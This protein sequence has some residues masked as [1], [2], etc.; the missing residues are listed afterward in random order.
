MKKVVKKV[1]TDQ[2]SKFCENN[3]NFHKR[4]MEA[5]KNLSAID[6][7]AV[8]IDKVSKNLVPKEA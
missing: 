7:V 3:S 2:L 8:I 5:I 6:I 4:Q 1:A